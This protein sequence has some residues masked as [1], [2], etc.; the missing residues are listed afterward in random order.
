MGLLLDV[1]GSHGA[2]LNE[3]LMVP[4]PPPTRSYAPV[5]NRD[6]VDLIDERTDKIVGLPVKSRRFGL[7]QKGQQMFGTYTFDVGDAER[8]LSIGFRNSY[9]KT[10]SV[11]IV[12][13]A[14]V[15][16]CSNLCFSGDAF[17]VVKK[18]TVNVWQSVTE[19]IDTAIMAA[20]TNY[21]ALDADFCAWKAVEVQ[22]ARGAELIG[23]A[24]YDG[25]LAPQQATIA[26]AD[27]RNARHEQFADRTAWS[28]YNCYTEAVKKG[29]AGAQINRST[30]VHDWFRGQHQQAWR[31]AA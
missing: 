9:N 24:L 17:K 12:T 28:L 13:G 3:V 2:S 5:S 14:S 23:R 4:P 26:M 1:A 16:V 8:G 15:F 25:V 31:T 11:G 18:H 6:L 21:Q 27:W 30:G 29:P 20:A 7:S 10:L 19:I 22:E